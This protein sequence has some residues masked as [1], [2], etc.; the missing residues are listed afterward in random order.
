[1]LTA[2]S[3]LCWEI[4][5]SMRFNLW[6]TFFAFLLIAGCTLVPIYSH[7][8]REYELPPDYWRT[9]PGVHLAVTAISLGICLFGIGQ[10]IGM[11]TRQYS[12]PVT[13]QT[14][15]ARR[16]VPGALWSAGL[17]SFVSVLFNV[18]FAA[19][20]P[21]LGPALT[22][23]VSFMVM[24][25][26]VY[27]F[28]GNDNRMGFAGVL[29][30]TVVMVW[31]YGHYVPLGP[32]SNRDF[33]AWQELSI[34]E[35]IILG[36]TAV[37]A[38]RSLVNTIEIDRH[39]AGWGRV[40]HA[41]E[42][43]LLAAGAR[44]KP[45][46]P[47]WSAST[48]VFW[49]EWKQNGWL[50]PCVLIGVTSLVA[51]LRVSYLIWSPTF[52]RM[53]G[54]PHEAELFALILAFIPL[55]VAA[56]WFSSLFTTYGKRAIA[57]QAWPTSQSTLP[58]SD[59]AFGWI[60]FMRCLVSSLVTVLGTLLVGFLWMGAI[61]IV[62]RLDGRPTTF[63]PMGWGGERRFETE[64]YIAS[65]V[66]VAWLAAGLSTAT[67]LSGRRWIAAIPLGIIPAWIALLYSSSMLPYEHREMYIL[68]PICLF[69][70]SMLVGTTLAYAVGTMWG[71]IGGRTLLLGGASLFVSEAIGIGL[72]NWSVKIANAQG[73]Y[74][75]DYGSKFVMLVVV[76]AL[77]AT[78]PAIVPL[79]TY[80]NRH[81]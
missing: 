56:P 52:R 72:W 50:V 68:T 20:W 53:P 16:L 51:I 23:A 79:A 55:S 22:Y 26:T 47:F 64:A 66:F 81:R 77:A 19:R 11:S 28:R 30:W 41:T 24:Y 13:S 44:G 60:I 10:G 69:L 8:F 27:R 14:L 78:P 71:V 73:P 7:Q 57:Q 38:W 34:T 70:G 54:T 37:L 40:I 49:F 21:F 76:L 43:S 80:Y 42:P 2:A 58:V 63:Q 74:S 75:G 45:L 12:F 5:R 65:M 25:A 61:E 18:L 32:S 36:F 46:R 4:R 29:M 59:S 17:Y 35:L 67:S 39:G 62:L 6:L 9:T 31:I 3:A 48:A 33:H 15:A 1:M